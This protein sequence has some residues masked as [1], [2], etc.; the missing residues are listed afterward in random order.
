MPSSPLKAR[1]SS[2]IGGVIVL[3][4]LAV[5]FWTY[6]GDEA[7]QHFGDI[8]GKEDPAVSS[9]LAQYKE[10]QAQDSPLLVCIRASL[11][12]SAYKRAGDEDAVAKWKGVE[13]DA[14]ATAVKS[15]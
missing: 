11:V 10:A 15:R 9:A 2:S 4:A 7:K 5:A 6:F 12:R 1:G 14:C 13:Q 8:F 3:V